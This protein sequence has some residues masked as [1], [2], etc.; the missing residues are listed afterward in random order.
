MSSANRNFAHLLNMFPLIHLVSFICKSTRS[1]LTCQVRSYQT[2]FAPHNPVARVIDNEHGSLNS[3]PREQDTVRAHC[4]VYDQGTRDAC[5]HRAHKLQDGT[6]NVTHFST[7]PR[8]K[9]CQQ[10]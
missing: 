3:N 4:T 2:C 10:P 7:T 6:C 8:D 5:E 9:Y 1:K